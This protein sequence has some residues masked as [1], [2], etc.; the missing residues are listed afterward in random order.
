MAA[1]FPGESGDPKKFLLKS[2][3]EIP[4]ISG[5]TS[6]FLHGT[7]NAFPFGSLALTCEGFAIRFVGR[8]C[9]PWRHFDLAGCA[10]IT[11]LVV[12]AGVY[13]TFDAF[14]GVVHLICLH[15]KILLKNFL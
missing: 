9:I 7:G 11:I 8:R 3:E 13:D 4:P 1:S 2:K 5:R 6:L 10:V 12:I 15:K 14:V